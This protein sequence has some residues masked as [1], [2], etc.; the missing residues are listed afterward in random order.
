M[1]DFY[2]IKTTRGFFPSKVLLGLLLL[3]CLS[4]C[5]RPVAADFDNPY[6]PQSINFSPF[7]SVATNDV[8]NIRALQAI[9]GG[10]FSGV[11]GYPITQ[12][13]I[14]W[15][16]HEDPDF[17]SHCTEEGGGTTSFTSTIISLSPSSKYY[18]R[19]YATNKEGTVWGQKQEF[20]TLD[21]LPKFGLVKLSE[22]T[23]TTV[24]VFAD[25]ESDGGATVVSRG[26]CVSYEITNIEDSDCLT[27]GEGTGTFTAIYSGLSAGNRYYIRA[28]AENEMGIFYSSSTEFSTLRIPIVITAPVID[29]GTS[30]ATVGGSV[31]LDRGLSVTER[32]VCYDTVEYPTIRDSCISAGFGIGSF[33]IILESLTPGM[34]YF[35]RAYALNSD[36]V[37]YGENIQFRTRES[38]KWTEVTVATDTAITSVHFYGEL[39]GFIT[40]GNSIYRTLDGGKSWETIQTIS[41]IQFTSV[42]SIDGNTV[43]AG[44]HRGTLAQYAY[45]YKSSDGGVSWQTMSEIWRQNESLRVEALKAQSNGTVVALVTQSPNSSQTYGHV[46]T[47]ANFGA[48]W[49]S[50]TVPGISGVYAMTLAQSRLIIGG[51]RRWTGTTNVNSIHRSTYFS[52]TSTTLQ[53][54]NFG[55]GSQPFRAIDSWSQTVVGVANNGYILLSNDEGVNWAIRR[56]SGLENIDL[57][58]VAV[59][60]ETTFIVVGNSGRLLRTSNS[61]LS[62]DSPYG[63]PTFANITGIVY[64]S[65][66]N[67]KIVT[68]DG[69]FLNFE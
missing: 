38:P 24:Q 55:D 8:I 17:G 6:D 18:V 40:A 41:D 50:V 7:P 47:S 51:G 16:S 56:I 29:I 2:N 44:G 26:I 42:Y 62:W 20:S 37:A 25:I 52:N 63:S 35:I 22:I 15:D 57:N 68:S 21:G 1:L 64:I 45:I 43:Y 53:S 58:G 67:L 4:N 23:D 5:D 32:G 13:G 48:V 69:V 61:G 12:K 36:G 65:D 59:V 19:A 28:F 39:L 10:S 60:S 49:T 34:N 33:S 11:S 27:A 30:Q 31:T 14:C 54:I 9:S 3:L 66:T 46:Y